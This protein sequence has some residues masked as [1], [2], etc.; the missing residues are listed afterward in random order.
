MPILHV[1]NKLT[2]RFYNYWTS[3]STL[4]FILFSTLLSVIATVPIVAAFELLGLT[5]KDIGGTDFDKLGI[6]GFI[7]VGVILAPLLE[8]LFFQ[9]LPIRLLQKFLNKNASKIALVVSSLLFSAAHATY[10]IWYALAIFPMGVV[11][12][13]AYIHF[14]QRNKTGFWVTTA[15]HALRNSLAII[16]FFG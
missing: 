3:F 16:T 9:L 12:A 10:S 1:I 2:L 5:E 15:I 6:D 14:Q 13:V 4:K 7:I 11:L 8:T